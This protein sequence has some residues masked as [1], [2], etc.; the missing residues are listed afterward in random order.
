VYSASIEGGLAEHIYYQSKALHHRGE[1]VCL[2]APKGFLPGKS[3]AFSTRYVL[4]NMPTDVKPFFLKRF[5]QLWVLCFNYWILAYYI[6]KTKPVI[7]LVDS[8]REYFAPFWSLP[9]KFALQLRKAICVVNLHDPVRDY[10]IGPKWWHNLSV[11]C[12]YLFIDIGLVHAA[13]PE[14][15]KIPKRVKTVEVPVGIY[16]L[17]ETT[18]TNQEM[19]ELW[20]VRPDQKIFLS[21]GYI[22]DN[23]NID[24][25]LHALTKVQKGFLVIA[26]K[27]QSTN[28]RPMMFYKNLAQKLGVDSR[29]FF[30]NDFIPEDELGNFFRSS[31]FVAL[32]YSSS[33]HSQSGVLNLAAAAKL[34]VIASG[35]DSP[36][37]RSVKKYNLGEVI[38]PDSTEEII[39]GM[40]KLINDPP[41]PDWDAYY[42]YA[43]WV[44]NVSKLM[45]AVKTHSQF[46]E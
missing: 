29:C 1:D 44:S 23:K 4:G 5:M 21:F 42:E 19:R 37:I 41:M 28:D 10:I 22:R 33:F 18:L 32:T 2:L 13:V 38:L 15:A 35:A 36:L 39:R 40:D 25:L 7:V 46:T 6:L 43:G 45:E 20:N 34:Q 26:G 3:K 24:L 14:T 11:R 16:E 8:Y 12:G 9:V 30:Y 31:D 17:P 27:P